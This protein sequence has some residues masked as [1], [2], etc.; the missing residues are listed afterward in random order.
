MIPQSTIER[1]AAANDIVEVINAVVPLKRVGARWM[2]LCP[3]HREKTPSF[4]VDPARQSYKCF[5]CGAGGSI[6]GFIMA[7]EN[8]DFPGA[9]RRLAERAGLVLAE[10]ELRS[11]E[12]D[13]AHGLR[14]RLIAL[15]GEAADWFHRQLFKNPDAQV[16]R[17]YLRKR[18]IDAQVARN[19]KL[20]YAPDQW[21]LLR[22]WARES[23]YSLEECLTAGLVVSREAEDGEG[24]GRGRR[25]T[26]DRF[27][28]RLMI[29]IHS[30]SGEVI[31]FSGR[32]LAADAKAAKY[33]NSPETPIFTKGAILFGLH[34]SRRA[35]IDAGRAI[36]CE[37]QLDLITAF[38]HGIHNV[39]APQ[40]TAFTP[41][42]A[43]LLKR[44]C[45][46]ALLCFD[47]DAAGQ[48]AAERSFAALLEANMSVKVATMP[49]GED[50][51]SMIR[52]QGVEAFRARLDAAQ[53][54]FDFQ[55]ERLSRMFDLEAPAGQAA[56][57][58]RLAESVR[59]VSDNFLRDA[60]ANKVSARLGVGP[61]RFRDLV[62]RTPKRNYQQE[63][64]AVQLAA[65]RAQQAPPLETPVEAVR[66][67]L[68]LALD[69]PETRDW[70][71]LR[72]DRE[73]LLKAASGGRLLERVLTGEFQ[74]GQ[75]ASV[76]AFLAT[77]EP[78]ESQLLSGLDPAPFRARA[79]IIREDCWL[80][81]EEERL[82]RRRD[83]AQQRMG[84]TGMDDDELT[85]LHGEVIAIQ[86]RLREIARIRASRKSDS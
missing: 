19:W 17:D 62:A 84:A 46:E 52:Q 53:D 55:I 70:L 75:P 66:Q 20:G 28:D 34:K 27:R 77:F 85:T 21:S 59:L 29:P 49:A 13:A 83:A 37:G 23:G 64:A 9:V 58:R 86:S 41:R 44:C 39:T 4:N 81:L 30:E 50:P 42:Q 43:A 16:A 11:G 40:G 79:E 74:P 10:D 32:V 56:F 69:D 78:R 65:K 6:F 8:L 51:D 26:Y 31:A 2:A 33:V 67:L 72:P 5:G 63:D 61:E 47:A 76:N 54:F 3:F 73:T 80:D 36:V 25:S 14:R 45:D 38:E 1:V 7:Y 22:D 24:G 60:V 68:A 15:H 12:A 82:L 35:I 18:G 48:Q 57:A 71:R